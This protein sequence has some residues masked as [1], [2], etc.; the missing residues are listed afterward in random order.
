[1]KRPR[2]TLAEIALFVVVIAIGL[3]AIRSG[4]DAWTGAIVSVTYFALFS[5]L[6]GIVF[7][8]K[9]RRVYW[10]GFAVLGWGYMMLNFLPW[11]DISGGAG[12]VGPA[13]FAYV[14]EIVH[15][16]PAAPGTVI[17]AGPNDLSPMPP[18]GLQSL[19]PGATSAGAVGGGFGGGAGPLVS[20]ADARTRVVKIGI[21][22][23]ALLW[24][25]LGGWIARYFASG[26]EGS[27]GAELSNHAE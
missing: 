7:G 20:N 27:M 1:M 2:F 11:L 16:D 4:S 14:G 17:P 12:L 24:A 8:R 19:P 9:S 5:A 3:A 21:A 6:L 13:L 15:P 26:P 22:L 10:V 18:S 25:F 23:E